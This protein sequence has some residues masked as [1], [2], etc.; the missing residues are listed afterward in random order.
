MLNV[1]II[2]HVETIWEESLRKYGTNLE[3]IIEKIT[4]QLKTKNYSRVI[5]NRFENWELEYEHQPIA[6]YITEINPYG[7][8]WRKD[9]FAKGEEHRYCEGGSHSE[10]VEIADWM[11]SLKHYDDI[12]ICGAFDGECI[13]DLEI[14]LRHLNLN[15]NRLNHLIV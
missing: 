9:N 7:Y 2:H 6:Q 14:A 3:T 5:L 15:Y 8:G 10:V 4:I 13:E 11:L 12:D 1:L